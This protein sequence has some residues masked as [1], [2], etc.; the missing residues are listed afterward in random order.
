M[1]PRMGIRLGTAIIG[2]MVITGTAVITDTMVIAT[3]IKRQSSDQSF[4]RHNTSANGE[5][6]AK[7]GASSFQQACDRLFTIA[8]AR[9]A[10]RVPRA[11]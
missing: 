3:V 9:G 2:A 6:P 10:R 8:I 11:E 1:Q 4:D 5:A 7:A